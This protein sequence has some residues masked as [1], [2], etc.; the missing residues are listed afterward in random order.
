[1]CLII[2]TY[3]TLV[4]LMSDTLRPS[5]MLIFVQVTFTFTTEISYHNIVL[6]LEY[7]FWSVLYKSTRKSYSS[8]SK[9]V[10]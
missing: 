10:V 6:L 5:L 7:D 9:D 1:M 3:D 8:Q 4:H 2:F